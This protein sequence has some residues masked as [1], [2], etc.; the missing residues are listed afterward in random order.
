MDPYLIVCA[1]PNHALH[2]VWFSYQCQFHTLWTFDI[3]GH[4]P[5]SLETNLTMF[6][7]FQHKSDFSLE[8]VGSALS[9]FASRLSRLWRW[10]ITILL[11][12]GNPSAHTS[13]YGLF[14]PVT[15]TSSTNISTNDPRCHHLVA[16]DGS[17]PSWG[18]ADR[19]IVTERWRLSQT[20]RRYESFARWWQYNSV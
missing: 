7:P 3:G 16:S 2:S 15:A 8:T 19:V 13:L 1:S 4:L 9:T 17:E 5:A 14:G 18:C 10:S 6:I 11:T 20:L 12:P